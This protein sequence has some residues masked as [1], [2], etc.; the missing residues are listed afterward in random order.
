MDGYEDE[1]VGA[2]IE[3]VRMLLTR[4]GGGGGVCFAR[5]LNGLTPV[6]WAAGV[7]SVE[8]LREIV[9]VGDEVLTVDV[10]RSPI[11]RAVS[12]GR[13]EAVMFLLERVGRCMGFEKRVD[14][15]T[16][17]MR[18]CLETPKTLLHQI[19]CRTVP[20][21]TKFPSLL[22]TLLPDPMTLANLFETRH[23]ETGDTPLHLLCGNTTGVSESVLVETVE[24][25]VKC[26][27]STTSRHLLSI[28]N[29]NGVTPFHAACGYSHLP[30]RQKLVKL[31][32]GFVEDVNDPTMD[33]VTPFHCAVGYHGDVMT[34]HHLLSLGAIPHL[35][36]PTLHDP[37][38]PTPAPLP[39]RPNFTALHRAA[40]M[41]H[42]DAV[43]FLVSLGGW[44]GCD[45]ETALHVAARS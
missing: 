28:K 23:V 38:N 15:R 24:W 21:S 27:P 4:G 31:L 16:I 1:E 5:D 14:P 6:C 35:S 26:L 41:L 30:P 42:L 9:G 13:R 40:E 36:T 43:R 33:G 8:M 17:F 44:E 45:G 10:L 39:P 12:R 7:G 29:V 25:V 11:C 18:L 2:K 22:Q 34:G 32:G 19:C 3:I 20:L 37:R